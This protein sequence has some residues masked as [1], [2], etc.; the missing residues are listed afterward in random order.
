MTGR[1]HA[2]LFEAKF[3]A[4]NPRLNMEMSCPLRQLDILQ[5]VLHRQRY[6]CRGRL[7]HELVV[8]QIAGVTK[9]YAKPI[10]L[11][12]WRVVSKL[13]RSTRLPSGSNR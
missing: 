12:C 1:D 13:A 8:F 9:L 11:I 3:G 10:S 6:D 4:L 5:L 2:R 7:V